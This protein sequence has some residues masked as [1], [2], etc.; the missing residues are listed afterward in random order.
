M[1]IGFAAIVLLCLYSGQVTAISGHQDDASAPVS[2]KL[3]PCQRLL[4]TLGQLA[5]APAMADTQ[6]E[7]IESTKPTVQVEDERPGVHGGKL[8]FLKRVGI[9]WS[10]N[11]RTVQF[12]AQGDPRWFIETVGEK[13][14]AFFGFRI[15]DNQHMTVPDFNEFSGAL[16]KINRELIRRGEDPIAMTF[17]QTESNQNVSVSDYTDRFANDYGI[18]IA[19][20]GNHLIHDL[21]F[22]TGAIF[23]PREVV[24]VKVAQVKYVHDFLS[25]LK[26]K[27]AGASED[28]QRVVKLIAFVLNMQQTRD[29]DGG[30]TL[31]P[32][33]LAYLRAQKDGPQKLKDAQKHITSDIKDFYPGLWTPKYLIES[34][35]DYHQL[36]FHLRGRWEAFQKASVAL[37]I[38]QLK[39]DFNQFS[40]SYKPR[41]GFDPDKNTVDNVEAW[42]EFEDHFCIEIT[43]R[44]LA[45]IRAALSIIEN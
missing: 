4:E 9:R 11:V 21:S 15:I 22:H 44:R 19:P 14:A 18:P 3:D 38:D 36:E 26:E 28:H 25:F 17:Y 40:S 20:S 43:Q 23:I 39:S 10:S 12:D 42:K 29:I 5:P 1:R 33:I 35:L 13:V 30:T 37:P 8:L 34:T 7:M 27:Y 6:L 45:I 24:K 16:G 41:A 2:A 32:S 31:G